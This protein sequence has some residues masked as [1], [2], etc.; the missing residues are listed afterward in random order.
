MNDS[1]KVSMADF[2]KG[3]EQIKPSEEKIDLQ[4]EASFLR[5]K[6]LD[7]PSSC[8][9]PREIGRLNDLL[10]KEPF[11]QEDFSWLNELDTRLF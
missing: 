9:T 11:S 4:K 8:F 3:A 7:A 2:I 6:L 10:Y 1:E 5:D